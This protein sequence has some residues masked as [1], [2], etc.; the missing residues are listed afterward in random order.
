MGCSW[1]TGHA[2][3]TW[4]WSSSCAT[5]GQP[6]QPRAAL[7]AAATL[8]ETLVRHNG[9]SSRR[10]VPAGLGDQVASAGPS[11]PTFPNEDGLLRAYLPER[12]RVQPPSPVGGA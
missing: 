12:E 11:R 10:T 6:Q 3:T 5:E 1:S 8:R 2:A 7:C 4:V 9:R